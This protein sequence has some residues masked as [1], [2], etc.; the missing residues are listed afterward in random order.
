MHAITIVWYTN[1]KNL[2]LI[3]IKCFILTLNMTT[4]SFYYNLST[5]MGFFFYFRM[6][7]CFSFLVCIALLLSFCYSCVFFCEVLL[8]E[9]KDLKLNDQI[10]RNTY[11]DKL[12]CRFYF[13]VF[14]SL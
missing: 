3:I 12:W 7:C 13:A 5:V 11:S 4:K 6:M 8:L 10:V 1:M 14:A 9:P 2:R